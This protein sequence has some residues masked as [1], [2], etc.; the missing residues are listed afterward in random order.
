MYLPNTTIYKHF[1]DHKMKQKNLLICGSYTQKAYDPAG[2]TLKTWNVSWT[3]ESHPCTEA[4]LLSE[5]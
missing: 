4:T 1:G 3:V 5:L 2:K